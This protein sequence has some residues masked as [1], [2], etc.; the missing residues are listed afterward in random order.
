MSDELWYVLSLLALRPVSLPPYS[1][2]FYP[3]WQK[4]SWCSKVYICCSTS[5]F[6]IF[7]PI[8]GIIFPP[9]FLLPLLEFTC[10]SLSFSLDSESLRNMLTIETYNPGKG[11]MITGHSYNPQSHNKEQCP[12]MFYIPLCLIILLLYGKVISSCKNV[13]LEE[14]SRHVNIWQLKGKSRVA[15]E[16]ESVL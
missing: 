8:M 1:S 11:V 12:Q 10:E 13:V 6:S 16:Q 5:S 9:V 14:S 4:G 2:F 15:K 7:T 3:Y